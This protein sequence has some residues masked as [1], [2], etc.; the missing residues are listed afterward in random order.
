MTR[1][2]PL[3]TLL[4]AGVTAGLMATTATAGMA[5]YTQLEQSVRVGLSSLQVN[6]DQLGD[7]TLDQIAQIS[8]IL[9]DG[10]T[11]QAKAQ[12][13]RLVIDTALHPMPVSMTSPEGLALMKTLKADLDRIGATYPGLDK[14]T[15]NQVQ[16]VIDTISH[17]KKDDER[18]RQAAEAQFADFDRPASVITT[19]SGLVQLEKQMDAKL[20]GL[21]LTPPAQGALTFGQVSQ[22]TAIFDQAGPDADQKAAAMKVL[23]IS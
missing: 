3:S 13:A 7:L 19:N 18:A 9:D 4:A 10:D 5:E 23:G 20:V 21:G 8:A 6:T 1:F 2:S 22:L 16:Q 11:N 14:L 15:A 17:H 12:A